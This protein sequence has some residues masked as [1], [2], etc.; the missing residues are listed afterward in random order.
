MDPVTLG[1]IA[2]ILQG[3]ITYGPGAAASL[4][5]LIGL[6]QEKGYVPSIDELNQVIREL[7]NLD[8]D[9]YIG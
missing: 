9:K 2:N 3:V 4:F 6:W 7:E 8:V 5:K 1:V